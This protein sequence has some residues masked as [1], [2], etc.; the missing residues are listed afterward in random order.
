MTRRG[1]ADMLAFL[2]CLSVLLGA[3]VGF[4]SAVGALKIYLRKLPIESDLRLQSLPHQTDTWVRL[5]DKVEKAEM[6]EELGTQNYITRFWVRRQDQGNPAAPVLEMHAAYYTGMIDTVPHVPERCMVGGGF[7]IATGTRSLPLHI[8]LSGWTP[9]PDSPGV[10]S[11]PSYATR[12]AVQPDGTVRKVG[13]RAR[14][15]LPRGIED[16]ALRATQF[17]EPQ[18]GR[19]MWAGYFFIANGGI[20]HSAED[21][22]RLAFDLRADYAYY[23][24]IQ[25]SGRY[26]SAEALAADAQSLLNELLPDLLLCVPD[27]VEVERG[28]YPPDNPRRRQAGADNRG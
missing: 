27:W 26:E 17:M 22:R 24:K 5:T 20:A 25:F 16:L 11:R 21:V 7:T 4:R 15:R 23:M 12:D 28:E 1:S 14:V 10:Y 9:E 6:L 8:D 18:T 19:T 13:V 3:A 2:V